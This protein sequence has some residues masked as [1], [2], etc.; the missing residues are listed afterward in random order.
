[1][2]AVT[3]GSRQEAMV[4]ALEAAVHPMPSV[5]P[6]VMA[7]LGGMKGVVADGPLDTAVGAEETGRDCP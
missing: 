3:D 2:V 7:V 6:D 5:A 4:A 1:M